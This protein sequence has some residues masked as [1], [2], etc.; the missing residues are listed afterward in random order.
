MNQFKQKPALKIS[1]IYVFTGVLWILLSGKFVLLFTS[2]IYKINLIETYKGWFFVITTGILLYMLVKKEISKRTIIEQE[3]IA[4]KDKAEESN[5]LKS[6]FLLNISHEI[7][8]PLNAILGFSD[9]LRRDLI[10]PEK[11]DK[12]I[13]YIK[14]RG[15]DLLNIIN[16]LIAISEIEANSISIHKNNF[17]INQLLDELND[18]YLKLLLL[19]PDKTIKLKT[20]KQLP[21][22]HSIIF[23]DEERIKQI[24]NNL[25]NNAIK[26]TESGFV[27]FGYTLKK[28]K[29]I[30]YV[31][32]TG[33]GIS[34]KNLNSIFKRFS[35]IESS[36]TRNYGGL[37]IGLS[38]SKSLVELLGG[39]IWIETKEGIGTTFSFELPITEIPAYT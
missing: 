21:T 1:L 14:Q 9:L 19:Y 33:I 24:L 8:T 20:H 35:Q 22:S 12:Y 39:I 29:L 4:S 15:L 7:R 13:S 32:D 11:K 34:D 27:E 18:F 37:G 28:N 16:D 6:A 3:L 38:I 10:V 26:F 2:D 17:C 36:L 23:S 31:S 30:F 5:R 25:L